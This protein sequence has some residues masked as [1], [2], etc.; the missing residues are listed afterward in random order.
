M[1]FRRIRTVKKIKCSIWALIMCTKLS[2]VYRDKKLINMRILLSPNDHI[3]TKT[4]MLID[5][6][7]RL[8]KLLSV[9]PF[10]ALL[11]VKCGQKSTKL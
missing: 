3:M 1:P 9:A 8:L 4:M 10:L 11:M 5:M 7:S 6:E 2:T